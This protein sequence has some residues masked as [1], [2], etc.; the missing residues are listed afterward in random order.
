MSNTERKPASVV[1]VLKVD[2]CSIR[3]RLLHKCYLN[4][5]YTLDQ[6]LLNSYQFVVLIFNFMVESVVD[7]ISTTATMRITAACLKICH[8]L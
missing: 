7:F 2:T 6:D 1:R 4:I 8:S 3:I 5:L